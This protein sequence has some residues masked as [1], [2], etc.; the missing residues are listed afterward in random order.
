MAGPDTLLVIVP[1]TPAD[2]W[3]E[4]LKEKIPGIDIHIHPTEM[5]AKEIPKDVPDDVWR[6]TSALYTWKAFPTRELAPNLQYVQLHSAGCGQ[7]LG[8]PL[9]EQTNITFSTSNGVHPPQISEWVF[10]TF[11]GFQHHLQEHLD[12]QRKNLW[13]DP[14][15]DEDV[16]DAVGLRVGILGYGCVGRQC[17]RVAKALGMDVYAYNLHERST[18]E[19][20][21]AAGGFNLPGLG[22][23]DGQ[24]PSRWFHGKEQLKDFLASDLDLLV[25]ALPQ[26]TET[27]NMIGKDEFALL[28]KKKTFLSNV[29]RGTVVDTNA[30][31]AALDAGHIRG[32]AL[33][34]TEPEP[35]PSDSKLWGYKNVVITPHCAGNSNHFNERTLKI[36]TH[37]LE[38]RARGIEV[39]NEVNR[40][41]AY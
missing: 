11:L 4:D 8:L 13:V 32:A 25:I 2:S 20:R 41:L 39:V 6:K 12:N 17:A 10:A 21:R 16:E 24:F 9:Y 19:S 7:I 30:L 26:T 22:D 14:P 5:Y 18:P 33:D 40:S 36:L 34:V 31:I 37:N 35:L 28:S 23:L 27:T 29:G 1:F 15:S 3:V 38:R